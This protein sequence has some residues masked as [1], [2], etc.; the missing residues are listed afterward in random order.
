[1]ICHKLGHGILNWLCFCHIAW[2]YIDEM[3]SYGIYVTNDMWLYYCHN[4]GP[5]CCLYQYDHTNLV[6][7][8]AICLIN[9]SNDIS[10]RSFCC[11]SITNYFNG[12][13]HCVGMYL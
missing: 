7:S 4:M 5:I 9:C 2:L 8:V 11:I 6:E 3:T 13:Y 1:M 12:G 10:N